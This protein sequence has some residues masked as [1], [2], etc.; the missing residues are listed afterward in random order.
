MFLD[1]TSLPQIPADDN[2]LIGVIDDK[3]L[4][5]DE[6]VRKCGLNVP[7][8][9]WLQRESQPEKRADDFEKDLSKASGARRK[10]S[11]AEFIRGQ[12]A[13]GKSLDELVA[14]AARYDKFTS[15]EIAE[16]GAAITA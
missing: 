9:P 3:P 12:L 15:R 1:P 8:N 13:L 16:I 14:H 2:E 7:E 11:I 10:A 5:L 6:L 4:S